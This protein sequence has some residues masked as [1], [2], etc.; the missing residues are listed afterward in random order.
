MQLYQWND[1]VH[2]N[3]V[4][5]LS[6]M[7]SVS[8]MHM[9]LSCTHIHLWTWQTHLRLCS[10]ATTSV[11]QILTLK[12]ILH[13]L[14]S[15]RKKKTNACKKHFFKANIQ[16]DDRL[17]IVLF[18]AVLMPGPLCSHVFLDEWLAGARL[19]LKEIWLL[20]IVRKW[21]G[22]LQGSYFLFFNLTY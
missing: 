1:I 21:Y 9:H 8:H 17:Y 2:L 6:G 22:C 19:K 14:F 10:C 13:T 3:M 4:I 15:Q 11:K 16:I 18:S 12:T 7:H 5:S 20:L